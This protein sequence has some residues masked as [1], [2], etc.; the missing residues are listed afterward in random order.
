MYIWSWR[1]NEL[2]GVSFI[3]MSFYIHQMVGL[4]SMCLAVDIQR[5]TAVL[6]FQEE[7]KAL[8][9]ASRDMRAAHIHGAIIELID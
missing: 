5:S 2:H 7:F 1:D 8:S 6:R 4:R 9:V 3:D